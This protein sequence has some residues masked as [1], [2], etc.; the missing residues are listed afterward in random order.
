MRC[1]FWHW[2]MNEFPKERLYF[3][4]EAVLHK[5]VENL[6]LVTQKERLL[7]LSALQFSKMLSKIPTHCHGFI[8]PLPVPNGCVHTERPH[9][10]NQYFYLSIPA[11]SLI[12][13]QWD[14]P[15]RC[16]QNGWKEAGCKGDTEEVLWGWGRTEPP[17]KRC[18]R[19]GSLRSLAER[20]IWRWLSLEARREEEGFLLWKRYFHPAVNWQSKATMP[21]GILAPRAKLFLPFC[22]TILRISAMKL[23]LQFLI[24]F[25]THSK[26]KAP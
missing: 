4:T 5:T 7:W 11:S 18:S 23:F 16:F 14:R 24:I 15:R 10:I 3:Q 12:W 2:T 8:R 19:N 1:F 26:K 13:K 21:N 20:L 22:S 25:I 6:L 9:W 17:P